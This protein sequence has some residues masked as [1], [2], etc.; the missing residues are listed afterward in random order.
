MGMIQTRCCRDTQV[1]NSGIVISK[2]QAIHNI[3]KIQSFFRG[4]NFRK[5]NPDFLKNKKQFLGIAP[6]YATN[7]IKE[8]SMNYTTESQDNNPKILKLKNLLPKFELDEKETYLLNTSQLKTMGLLY[9][10]NIIYKGTVNDKFQRE[11]FGKLFLNDGS[12]YE[13]FFKE[14]RMEGRGRFLNI[15]GFIYEGEFKNN[16]ASGYGKYV[17]LDGTIYKGTWVNNKQNGIGDVTYSDNSHYIG[18][19]INGLKNGKGKFFFPE[20]N[21]YEG[22][23]IN[24]EIKGEGIYKWRDGRIYIGFWE[25][26]KMNGY[27]IFMW[28]DCKKYYG[29]Y[30]DNN[31]D[32]FGIFYWADGKKFEGFWKDGKQHG[33]G[34][35]LSHKIK[36]YGE[37]YEGK[38]IKN[39][40]GE[41]ECNITQKYIDSVKKDSEFTDFERNI[42][43]YEKE[44][45]IENF[46]FE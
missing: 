4:F 17:G 33:Y 8:I 22:N 15:E 39:I 38:H 7:Q 46:Y 1:K 44:I 43:R 11:G 6:T 37:W 16:L 28:P 23:F 9:P 25:E 13:G 2:Q 31:K 45:G 42:E 27:G 12:I 36:E 14:N 21:S 35:I 30:V 29:H 18:N 32:G 41:N 5:K 40:N 20:G 19:F 3:I 26:N 34:L 24:N 10:N